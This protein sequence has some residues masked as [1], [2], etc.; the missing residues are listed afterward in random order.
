[1]MN[2]AGR[3]LGQPLQILI[4]IV[5]PT[6]STWDHWRVNSGRPF[7]ADGFSAAQHVSGC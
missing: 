3:I 1:M 4:W 7:S 6:D 2:H 5:V